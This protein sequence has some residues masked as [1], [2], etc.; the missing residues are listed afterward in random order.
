MKEYGIT[1]KMDPLEYYSYFGVAWC[2]E[3]KKDFEKAIHWALQ[4]LEHLPSDEEKE[5]RSVYYA[6]LSTWSIELGKFEEAVDF[7]TKGRLCNP[8]NIQAVYENVKALGSLQGPDRTKKTFELLK[9]LQE[10]QTEIAGLSMLTRL[11]TLEY[12][13]RIFIC[14]F[15]STPEQ[16]EFLISAFNRSEQELETQGEHYKAT[17]QRYMLAYFLYVELRRFEDAAA[18]FENI[19]GEDID[20][21]VQSADNEDAWNEMKSSCLRDLSDIYFKL[22]MAAK[23]A[24]GD[25]S[26][27]ITKLEGLAKKSF[28]N[29]EM[30]GTGQ[31]SIA[32]GMLYRQDGKVE[33]ADNATREKVLESLAILEDSIPENDMLGYLT[34]GQALTSAGRF[35]DGLAAYAVVYIT[36]DRAKER[37]ARRLKRAKTTRKVE[38]IKDV[39][40]DD[41]ADESFSK[42]EAD[43]VEAENDGGSPDA[44]AP[45]ADDD[46][47]LEITR[48]WERPGACDGPCRRL[49]IEFLELY[50]CVNCMETSLCEQCIGLHRTAGIPE[51]NCSPS[52]IYLKIYP[53]EEKYKGLATEVVNGILVPR[54]EWLDKLRAEWTLVPKE[55][56]IAES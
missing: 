36:L 45:T 15:A 20:N 49:G 27:F 39:K 10:Q 11:L 31:A 13:I 1:L 17:A 52:H 7:A 37:H 38:N 54:K 34:L 22:A 46:D 2:Y 14:P 48:F 16:R 35:E 32:L 19:L 9:K 44:H 40:L 4:A 53:I 6:K 25:I 24:G 3:S 30:W 42:R 47:N 23:E 50:D 51:M 18:I 21:S 8:N 26:P 33:E 5:S 56:L 29:I 41:V 12:S 55:E 28:V 43:N